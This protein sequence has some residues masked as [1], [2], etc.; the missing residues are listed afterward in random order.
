[1]MFLK[2]IPRK[3]LRIGIAALIAAALVLTLLL[4]WFDAGELTLLNTHSMMD[5]RLGGSI[6]GIRSPEDAKNYDDEHYDWFEDS[7]G[8]GIA[9]LDANT[10]YYLGRHPDAGF[11]GYRVIGFSSSEKY[12]SVMGIRVGDDE[13]E[14]KTALLNYNFKMTGGGFNTCRAVKGDVTVALSFEHG[15]VTNIAAYL[16][17]TSFFA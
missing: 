1:M 17:T 10:K 2:R 13:L 16:D 14:A 8:E 11:G 12:Y 7:V 6:D 4:S 5:W 15:V 9:S 3:T